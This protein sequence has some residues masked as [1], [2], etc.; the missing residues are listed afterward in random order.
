MNFNT[1]TKLIFSSR[2]RTRFDDLNTLNKESGSV[3]PLI[4]IYRARHYFH[5]C[6]HCY[7]RPYCYLDSYRLDC[8]RP[9]VTLTHTTNGIDITNDI[10]WVRWY[11]I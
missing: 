4:A 11:T 6:Q 5:I 3:Y 8:I 10:M 7:V 2:E 9:M 1:Y